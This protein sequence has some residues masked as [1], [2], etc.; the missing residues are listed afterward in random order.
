MV[1]VEVAGVGNRRM[2]FEGESFL[3]RDLWRVAETPLDGIILL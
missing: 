1:D 2:A 3:G